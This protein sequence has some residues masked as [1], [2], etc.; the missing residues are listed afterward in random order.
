MSFD[1]AMHQLFE[2]ETD[3]NFES[4]LNL[5]KEE[6]HKECPYYFGYLSEHDKEAFF[7]EECL[8]CSRVVDCIL[9]PLSSLNAHYL[10]KELKENR[11]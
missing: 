7:P 2:E 10:V 5:E 1:V 3:S 8:V 9:L 6:C 11:T 4:S